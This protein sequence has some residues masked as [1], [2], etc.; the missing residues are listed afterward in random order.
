M[1][2]VNVVK[3]VRQTGG[4]VLV[5]AHL[6]LSVIFV[7]N[8]VTNVSGVA[9]PVL[10]VVNVGQCFVGIVG[11]ALILIVEIVIALVLVV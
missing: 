6:P 8:I 5:Y 3:C 7:V 1:K 10:Y 4:H 11:I 9:I 2:A